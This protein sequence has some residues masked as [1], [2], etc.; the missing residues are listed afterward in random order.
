[1]DR[2]HAASH[3]DL[4]VPQNLIQELGEDAVAPSFEEQ[5]IAGRH[6]A[7]DDVAARFG[8]GAPVSV[9]HVVDAVQCLKAAGKCEYAWIRPGWI[10]TIGQNELISDSDA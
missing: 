7:H 3:P 2:Q 4:I 6:W 10:V 1:M 8:F 9:E 5:V